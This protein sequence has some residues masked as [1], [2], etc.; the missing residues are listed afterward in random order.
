VINT[1]LA[2]AD[3]ASLQRRHDRLQK[4]VHAGD[5]T[6]RIEDAIIEKLA[7]HL[8]SGRPAITA[9][10]T[11]EEKAIARGFFLLT[12]KPTIFACNVAEPDLAAIS[13]GEQGSAAARHRELVQ[14]YARHHSAT[15]AIV[16]SAPIES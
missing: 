2:L 16:L 11:S 10:L 7:A 4:Q 8:D 13:T 9:E 14:D 5:K 15:E 3:M 6:A 12:S 1:E